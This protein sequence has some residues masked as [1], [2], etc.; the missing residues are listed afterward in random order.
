MKLRNLHESL[1]DEVEKVFEGEDVLAAIHAYLLENLP[2]NFVHY[3]Y[4][5]EI[6]IGLAIGIRAETITSIS[7]SDEGVITLIHYPDKEKDP[8]D[9]RLVSETLSLYDPDSFP[10]I[11]EFVNRF[12]YEA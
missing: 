3:T 8:A 10:K 11:L 4:R 5:G 12:D 6:I 2:D 9:W 7:V 1:V